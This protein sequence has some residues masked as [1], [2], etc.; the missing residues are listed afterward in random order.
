MDTTELKKKK[1]VADTYAS[2][3][4]YKTSL[5]GDGLHNYRHTHVLLGSET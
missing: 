4:P 1:K 5:T 2:K 3:Y